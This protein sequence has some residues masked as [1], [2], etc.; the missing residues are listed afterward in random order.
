ME[1][2]EMWFEL[3]GRMDENWTGFAHAS[4]ISWNIKSIFKSSAMA[5]RLL[6]LTCSTRTWLIYDGDPSRRFIKSDEI[7]A[8]S[9]KK[10]KNQVE[11]VRKDQ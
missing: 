7:T 11:T 9:V 10:T 4:L 3:R 6:L 5:T 2:G 1:H 8:Y